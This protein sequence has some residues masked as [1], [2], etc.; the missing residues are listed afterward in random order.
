M[1]L[2]DPAHAPH[3]KAPALPPAADEDGRSQAHGTP[4]ETAPRYSAVAVSTST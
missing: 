2:R 3:A 1:R 4:R